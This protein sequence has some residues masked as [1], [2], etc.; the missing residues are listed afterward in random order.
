MQWVA[1]IDQRVATQDA[2]VG[3][4]QRAEC[5]LSRRQR[6]LPTPLRPMASCPTT[7]PRALSSLPGMGTWNGK[8][9]R[10]TVPLH[11]RHPNNPPSLQVR[12]L[13]KTTPTPLP[14]SM[15]WKLGQFHC[16]CTE[17]ASTSVGSVPAAAFC[18]KPQLVDTPAMHKSFP[19][20]G[21][22]S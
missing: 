2:K 16:H 17:C 11:I 9:A 19:K 1:I 12:H 15:R 21:G 3:R 14:H 20:M 8:G 18:A 7:Q 22:G 4:G 6:Y 5:P 10:C 13:Q